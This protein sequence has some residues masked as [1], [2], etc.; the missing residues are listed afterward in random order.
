MV[1]PIKN[2][3][4]KENPVVVHRETGSHPKIMGLF[5]PRRGILILTYCTEVSEAGPLA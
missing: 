3:H 1:F 4:K 2:G 5:S